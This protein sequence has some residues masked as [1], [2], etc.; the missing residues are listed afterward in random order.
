M[1]GQG[2]SCLGNYELL[3]WYTN[4]VGQFCESDTASLILDNIMNDLR[5]YNL[6]N[7]LLFLVWSFLYL[8]AMRQ[9][10]VLMT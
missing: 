5:R 1:L 6:W 7:Q 8:V 2:T 9:L 3:Y 4:M 10:F